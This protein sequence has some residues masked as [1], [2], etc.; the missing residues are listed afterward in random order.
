MIRFGICANTQKTID[1]GIGDFRCKFYPCI[2][3][4]V[5]KGNGIWLTAGFILLISHCFLMGEVKNG[6]LCQCNNDHKIWCGM[7]VIITKRKHEYFSWP[8]NCVVQEGR[9]TLKQLLTAGLQQ[10]FFILPKIF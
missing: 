2:E 7:L 8:L 6:F 10:L 5:G 3:V 4:A 1:F 9:K